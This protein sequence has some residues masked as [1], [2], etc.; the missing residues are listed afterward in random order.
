MADEKVEGLRAQGIMADRAVTGLVD[1]CFVERATPRAVVR[2]DEQRFSPERAGTSDASSR[3]CMGHARMQ[4]RS[5]F[6]RRR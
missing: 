2:A 5:D 3:G 4:R 1:R 6:S